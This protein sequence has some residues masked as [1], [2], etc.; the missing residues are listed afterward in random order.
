MQPTRRPA[1]PRPALTQFARILLTLGSGESP[2][3]IVAFVLGV[4]ALGVL[5]NFVFTLVV[6]PET[7]TWAAGFRALASVAVLIAAA[8]GV[9]RYDLGAAWRTRKL[10]ATFDEGNIAE[11]HAGLIWLMS[12]GRI[13]LPLIAL[14]HHSTWSVGERLRHCWILVT[15]DAAEACDR[16]ALRVPELG[17]AIE[18]HRVPLANASVE[19]TY[20]A[21]EMIYQVAAPEVGLAPPQIIADLTGGQKPMSAGMVLACL[22]YGRALEYI[23]SDYDPSGKLID[24]SQ[25]VL[26]A[27]VDFAAG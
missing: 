2:W 5:S 10:R 13:E 27:G 20:R 4:T 24:G 3:L 8:Y 19:N 26:R 22:P 16:L 9:Y 1:F 7:L 14:Q 6:N 18:L 17:Y 21:V 15:P 25:R 11:A 23:E 12:K